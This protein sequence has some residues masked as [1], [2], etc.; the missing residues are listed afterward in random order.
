MTLG[1]WEL[2][3]EAAQGAK[4]QRD[5]VTIKNKEGSS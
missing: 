5:L 4:F 2:P 3:E 1:R